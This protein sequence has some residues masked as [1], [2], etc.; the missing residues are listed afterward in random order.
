MPLPLHLR[1]ALGDMRNNR[2]LNAVTV[3]TIALA[4]MIVSA[5]ALFLVNASDLLNTW[6]QGIRLMVYLDDGVSEA[7]RLQIQYSLAQM[8][9]VKAARFISKEE[10]LGRLRRQMASQA[11]LLEGLDEN[12]LPAAYEV[13]LHT[14]TEAQVEALAERI[15]ALGGIE[16]VVYGRQWLKRF[17][18]LIELLR[19][20]GYALGGLFF[21]AAVFFVANTIR[22][23]LYSRQEEVAI[24]RLVGAT[25]S[26]I[27]TPF[28]IEALLQGGIGGLLGLG[29]L[30]LAYLAAAG[31][32]AA[33][34]GGFGFSFRFLPWTAGVTVVAS[35]MGV[36]WLGCFVSLKQFIGSS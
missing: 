23:V 25:E 15:E 16:E 11:K 13:E 9:E 3:I 12:P 35:A 31:N 20:V 22:L 4:V 30:Y 14:G 33:T 29:T 7:R 10:A 21:L 6:R 28:Y 17:G 36:G 2:F 18:G 8:D 32:V 19:I 26:F 24:M 34:L 5:F 27:R 1:K